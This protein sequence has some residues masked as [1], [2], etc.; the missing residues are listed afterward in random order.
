MHTNGFA[1]AVEI[2]CEKDQRFSAEGYAFLRDALNYTIKQNR[3]DRTSS[4]RHVSGQE[5][6]EGT[7]AYALKEFGPM[8]ATVLDYWG[9]HAT[10]DFGDMVFNL[11]EAGIFGKTDSDSKQDF[12]DCY[13]FHEAFV[14]PF[15]PPK[16]GTPAEYTNAAPAAEFQ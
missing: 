8:V 15:L 9:I 6:M 2:I 4:S 16:P 5:L 14:V 1:E 11:I 12:K 7:R 3:R 10:A 13:D